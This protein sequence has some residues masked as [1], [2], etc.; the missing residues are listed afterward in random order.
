MIV[1]TSGT[2]RIRH[3]YTGE[4]YALE[5]NDIT[6]EAGESQERSM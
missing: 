2:A 1:S 3:K 5:A 6:W 4:I